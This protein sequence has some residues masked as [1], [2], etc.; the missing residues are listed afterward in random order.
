MTKE[1]ALAA[2]EKRREANKSIKRKRNDELPAGAPMYFYCP[3]CGAE[4]VEPEGYITRDKLCHDC[5]TLDD[6]GWKIP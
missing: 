1:E 4:L 3:G 6:H 2:L 5:R